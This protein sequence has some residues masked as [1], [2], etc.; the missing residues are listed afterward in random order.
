MNLQHQP[1]VPSGSVRLVGLRAWLERAV[2]LPGVLA[3]RCVVELAGDV[4]PSVDEA[5]R[6]PLLGERSAQPQPQPR[7]RFRKRAGVSQ[8]RELVDSDG[9]LRGRLSVEFVTAGTAGISAGMTDLLVEAL[10]ATVRADL[11]EIERRQWG[12]ESDDL[13]DHLNEQ[14][15]SFELAFEESVVGMALV[16]LRTPDAGRLVRVNDRLR[17]ITGLSSEQLRRRMFVK[18]MEPEYRRPQESAYRRVLAGRR[19]PFRSEGR[20]TRPDGSSIWIRVTAAPLLDDMGDPSQLLVQVEELRERGTPEQELSERLDEVTGLLNPS[21]FD[22]A[23][24]AV[25]DRARR[26]ADTAAVYVASIEPWE[27]MVATHGPELAEQIERSLSERLRSVLRVDDAIARLS[28]NEFAFLAEEI[29]VDDA[30]GL[31][32][33]VGNALSAPLD[34]DG[35]LV[36]HQVVLGAAMV[37]GG[38]MTEQ[39]VIERAKRAIGRAA[40][41]PGD[42]GARVRFELDTEGISEAAQPADGADS[43]RVYRHRRR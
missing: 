3:A 42:S 31:A 43:P 33:R 4:T 32:D 27:S 16:P 34:I 1:A 24:T 9:R 29:G 41:V 6:L 28:G 22:R 38:E 17:H 2:L 15:R 11:L 8:Q 12:V 14:S 37:G 26:T 21:A 7:F 25:R 23:V 5:G 19:S 20:F 13:L 18:L 30:T 40:A 35:V 36:Q 10:L 39:E